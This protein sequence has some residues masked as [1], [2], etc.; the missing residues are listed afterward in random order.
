MIGADNQFGA[1]PKHT[2]LPGIG[3]DQLCA[4]SRRD[5]FPIVRFGGGVV[6]P[7]LPQPLTRARDDLPDQISGSS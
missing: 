6:A 2:N 7:Q 4:L 5:K 3:R 1:L